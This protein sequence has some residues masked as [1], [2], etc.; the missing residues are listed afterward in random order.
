MGLLPLT[1]S[2]T[3]LELPHPNQLRLHLKLQQAELVPKM[4]LHCY[5]KYTKIMWLLTLRHRSNMIP[6]SK[7]LPKSFSGKT[8]ASSSSKVTSPSLHRNCNKDKL[9]KRQCCEPI[10][11]YLLDQKLTK[12]F[13][14][15]KIILKQS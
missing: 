6:T 1:A 9:I 12:L 8:N 2:Q 5:L 11:V 14:H 13:Q 3:P 10:D 15:G 7:R 4:Y